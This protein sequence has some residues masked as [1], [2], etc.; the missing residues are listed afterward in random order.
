MRKNYKTSGLLYKLLEKP[1]KFTP[2]EEFVVN[3]LSK[4]KIEIEVV[5]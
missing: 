2:Y 4:M 3:T 1:M 5:D